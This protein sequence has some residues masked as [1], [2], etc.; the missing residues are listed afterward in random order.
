M[1][2]G[3]GDVLVTTN[4]AWRV[5]KWIMEYVSLMKDLPT[6]SSTIFTG[7]HE[8]VDLFFLHAYVNFVSN[9]LYEDDGSLD[10]SPNLHAS[11]KHAVQ[12]SLAKHTALFISSIPS[13]PVS[14]ILGAGVKRA[15][16]PS[17]SRSGS[18]ARGI[19]LQRTPPTSLSNSGNLYGFRERIIT[20]D[21]ITTISDFLTQIRPIICSYIPDSEGEVVSSSIK[22]MSRSAHDLKSAIFSHGCALLLPVTWLTEAVSQA[23]YQLSEPPSE[24]AVWTKKLEKQL[25]L[26]SAQ[27][28]AVDGI[29]QTVLW[30]FWEYFYPI[31]AHSIVEGLSQVKK[32]TLEG[33]SAMSLDLQ[34]VTRILQITSP[35]VGDHAAAPTPGAQSRAMN[36]IRYIDDYI[37]AFYVPTTEIH[38]WAATHPGYTKSQVLALAACIAESSGLR[39]K[40][41]T[42]I[43]AEVE[44]NLSR[45]SLT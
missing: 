16:D 21:V 28:L 13:S 18:L 40:D 25:Q 3:D 20:C 24:A 32:C 23:E 37:K 4:A 1:T 29:S 2:I 27:L 39:K 30:E 11:M 22:R 8:I 34:A 41:V 45:A 42:S 15:V 35:K 12:V 17:V 5:I 36:A 10:V 43:V 7:L 38:Q 14:R 44:E 6:A 9:T 31:I 26:L 19:S 33:R